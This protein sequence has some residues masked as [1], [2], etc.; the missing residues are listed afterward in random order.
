M[1]DDSC[2]ICRTPLSCALHPNQMS[3]MRFLTTTLD[4]ISDASPRLAVAVGMVDTNS[5]L[6]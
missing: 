3:A 1:F 4:K 6:R 5:A 2:A